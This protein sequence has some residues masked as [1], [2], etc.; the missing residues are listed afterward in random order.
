MLAVQRQCF[1][2]GGYPGRG[3]Q[4]IGA[5]LRAVQQVRD[6]AFNNRA[7]IVCPARLPVLVVERGDERI[8]FAA[9]YYVHI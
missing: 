8:M 9:A 3:H 2:D 7:G 5:A 4:S 6:I 1:A